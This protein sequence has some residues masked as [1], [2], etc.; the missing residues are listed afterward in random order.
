[1]RPHCSP[2]GGIDKRGCIWHLPAR[3]GHLAALGFNLN[4][5]VRELATGRRVVLVG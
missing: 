2:A 4:K 3:T 1:M 5:V